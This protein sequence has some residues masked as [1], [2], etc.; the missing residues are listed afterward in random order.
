MLLDAKIVRKNYPNQR[1]KLWEWNA[2]LT[3]K[4]LS[5]ITRGVILVILFLLIMEICFLSFFLIIYW[6]GNFSNRTGLLWSSL[7]L[8]W[9]FASHCFKAILFFITVNCTFLWDGRKTLHEELLWRPILSNAMARCNTLQ[10]S[11]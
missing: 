3:G 11:T 9:S 7:Y 1:F 8:V 2:S 10:I 5:P 6:K 4:F